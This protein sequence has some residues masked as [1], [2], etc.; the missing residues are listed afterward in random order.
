MVIFF[1]GRVYGLG[2][3]ASLS[4]DPVP[5]LSQ[6]GRGSF[7]RPRPPQVTPERRAA[8]GQAG[9]CRKGLLLAGGSPKGGV[10]VGGT[11]LQRANSTKM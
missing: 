6:E 7:S 1:P 2:M 9:E 10:A 11:H 4:S 8:S 5:S 3:R